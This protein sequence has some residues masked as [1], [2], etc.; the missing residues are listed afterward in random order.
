M[1]F[2]CAFLLLAF[3]AVCVEAE[4]PPSDAQQ[5]FAAELSSIVAGLEKKSA[6]AALG[7]DGWLFFGG[8]LRLL[9]LGRFW[10]AEAA[11]VSRAHKTDLADPVPAIID[12]YQQLRA[13]GIELL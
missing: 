13:R 1:R 9:S 4:T 12:F 11:K 10:G 5:K 8:G 6:A 7:L 2:F 3:I